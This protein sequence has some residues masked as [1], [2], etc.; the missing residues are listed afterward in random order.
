[1]CRNDNQYDS[2]VSVPMTGIRKSKRNKGMLLLGQ[3]AQEKEQQK[4]SD[5]I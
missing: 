2:F 3:F 5:N 4:R 1:M